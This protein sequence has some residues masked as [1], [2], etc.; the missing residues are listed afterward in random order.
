MAVEIDVRYEGNLRCSATHLH[1]GS[2]LTTDAPLDNGGKGEAFSPTDLVATG[3]GTCMLTVMGLVAQRRGIDI[4]G[5]QVRVI[6]EM[7]ARPHR[8]IGTLH[9]TLTMPAGR[10]YTP[11]ERA[12]LERAA[13]LCPAKSSLHPD[14]HVAVEFVYPP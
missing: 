2:V 4:A 13:D 10:Q 3:V 1:S 6:K 12:I 7:V 14:V 11:E 5:A 8:R 9:V